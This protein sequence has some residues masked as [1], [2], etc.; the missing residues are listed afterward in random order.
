MTAILVAPLPFTVI[1]GDAAANRPVS[2]LG[3]NPPGL[4]WRVDGETASIVVQVDTMF[5]T[6]AL[7]GSNLRSFDTVRVRVGATAAATVSAPS[8][9]SSAVPAWSGTKVDGAGAKTIIRAPNTMVS[10]FVRIDIGA[11]GHLD[12]FIEAQRLV[13][14]KAI[15]H[16]AID[17]DAETT[18]VDS[19]PSY[20]GP[21]WSA[22][23]EYVPLQQTKA[24]LSWVSSDAFHAE[25]APFL[26]KVGI[27]T[28]VLL[29]PS[30]EEVGRH[31]TTA[32]FGH[33]QQS[34]AVR[35]PAWNTHNL[36]LTVRALAP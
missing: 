36:E 17:R 2:N 10:R 18:W 28:P 5:D 4:V 13:I 24:A 14:G 35:H 21:N 11:P 29:V 7:I 26:S 23:D 19:S 27:T 15:Q 25:W 6:V 3:K 9:D 32:L 22:F 1:S 33:V 8:F 30:L 20:T 34:I 12:G 16:D 31:Q